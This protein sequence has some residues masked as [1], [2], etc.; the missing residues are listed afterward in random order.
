M[1]Y[2]FVVKLKK[3]V[4]FCFFLFIQTLN[5]V[6]TKQGGGKWWDEQGIQIKAESKDGHEPFYFAAKTTIY[7]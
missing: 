4:H 1:I 7:M 3:Q 5:I 6:H 2:M